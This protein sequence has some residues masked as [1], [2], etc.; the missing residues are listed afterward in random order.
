MVWGRGGG[1]DWGYKIKHADLPRKER[2]QQ[3]EAGAGGEVGKGHGDKSAFFVCRQ[4]PEGERWL[5]GIAWGIR[6]LGFLCL[7][8]NADVNGVV[9]TGWD[10]GGSLTNVGSAS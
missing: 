8:A 7:K 9:T 6:C 1:G 4:R 3:R 2:R 10:E 5:L